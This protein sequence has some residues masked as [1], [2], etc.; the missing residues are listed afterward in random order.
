MENRLDIRLNTLL[1]GNNILPLTVNFNILNLTSK[2]LV[3]I[4]GTLDL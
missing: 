1:Y 3:N 4:A 2:F